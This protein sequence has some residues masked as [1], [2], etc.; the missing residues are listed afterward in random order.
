M[1]VLC[2]IKVLGQPIIQKREDLPFAD[3]ALQN[4]DVMNNYLLEVAASYF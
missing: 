2:Y 3:L 4:I 1:V